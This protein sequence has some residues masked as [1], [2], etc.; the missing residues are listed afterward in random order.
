M[1]SFLARRLLRRAHP[2]IW[3]PARHLTDFN[4][5]SPFGSAW[6]GYLAPAASMPIQTYID[7]GNY[8]VTSSGSS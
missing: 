4:A 7:D 1:P 3:I 8:R 5:R 2:G 6:S